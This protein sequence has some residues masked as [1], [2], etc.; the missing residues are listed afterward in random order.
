MVWGCYLIPIISQSVFQQNSTWAR[1]GEAERARRQASVAERV[2]YGVPSVLAGKAS[3]ARFAI[4][5]AWVAIHLALVVFAWVWAGHVLL[6]VAA[7]LNWVF[8]LDLR[9]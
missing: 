5:S 4:C 7:A 8:D 6:L 2:R 9:E 3:I 1:I